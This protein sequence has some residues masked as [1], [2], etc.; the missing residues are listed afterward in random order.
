M[1]AFRMAVPAALALAVAG[2][3]APVGPVSVT[4]FS[5]PEAA[6]L[7]RGPIRVAAAPGIDPAGLEVRSYESA[8]AGE[9]A[10][11][12][13]AVAPV[14][15]V[16]DPALPVAEVQVGREQAAGRGASPV[17]LG[18]GGATGSYGGG[19]GLGVSIPLGRPPAPPV[20]TTLSVRIRD[21]A[22]GKALW[23]GRA[24]FTVAASSPLAQ[25]QLAAPKLAAALFAGFP[26][27]SGETIEVP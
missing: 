22:G 19:V 16:A 25:T 18:L 2:C 12:G 23:E 17:Q 24:S 11:L 3:V 4:R 20:T 8:V 5:V 14:D 21:R 13:H 1:R 9:L 6:S 15:A 7:G 10:R 27:R 26:G